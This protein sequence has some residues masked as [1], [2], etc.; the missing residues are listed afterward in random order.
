MRQTNKFIT[1][2]E[3]WNIA[4]QI[5]NLGNGDKA[6]VAGEL[7][8]LKIIRGKTIYVLAESLRIMGILLQPFMP[9]K[10]EVMLDILGVPVDRRSFEF[11]GLA[12]DFSYGEPMRPVGRSAHDGLFPPLEA[13]T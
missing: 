5:N 8:R 6:D 3:P 13:E 11:A 4:K 1:V 7:Q 10:A 12:K 9:E 2:M